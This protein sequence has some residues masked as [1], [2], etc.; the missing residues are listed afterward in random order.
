MNKIKL[1]Q[2]KN[3]SKC[4]YKAYISQFNLK[5]QQNKSSAIRK[6]YTTIIQNTEYNFIEL[7]SEQLKTIISELLEDTYFLTKQEKEVE[8]TIILKHMLRYIEFENRIESN[9][10][11]LSKKISGNVIIGENEIEVKCDMVFENDNNIEIVKYRTSVTKLSL[12]ARTESN[13]IPNDMELFLLKKLGEQLY[14]EQ[15]KPIIS[16]FYHLKGKKDEKDLYKQFLE[17]KYVLIKQV[18]DLNLTFGG[19]KKAQ[20]AIDKAIKDISDVLYF[21][22]S[23][24]N[25]V[26]TFDYDNDLSE[27]IIELSNT[28]LS[29]KSEKCVSSDC[30][31]CNFSTL[32][33]HKVVEKSVLEEVKEVIK[34]SKPMKPTKAQQEVIDVEF[35]NYRVNASAG[36]GKTSAVVER[37]IELF[38][39][40][41]TT[42][43]ILLITYTSKGAEQLK[44]KISQSNMENINPKDLNIFTF[45]GFGDSIISKEWKQLGF[46]EQPKLAST[47]DVNDTIKEL[48]EEYNKIEWLNYKNPL[49]N[50]PYIKG[51]FIQLKNYFNIIK[52][53][54]YN[55]FSLMENI[56]VK[57]KG[58]FT[59]EGLED[60]SKLIFEMYNKFN[61]K[62]FKQN[63]LQYQDQLLYLIKLLEN[64]ETML[65][66][67]G[68]SHIL[69]DEFQDSNPTQ[70]KL[71]HILLKYKENKSFMVVGDEKQSIFKFNCTSP[72]NILNFHKE[73]ENVKDINLAENF[74]STPQICNVANKL[75]RLNSQT[76]NNDMVSRKA[77]GELPKL[78]KFKTLSDENKYIAD[79]IET[80]I[81]EGISKHEICYIA[82]TKKEL[83]EMQKCLN[84]RNIDN[85]V[86][87]SELYLDN[88]YVQS[89]INLSNFFKDMEQ[90]YYLMEYILVTVDNFLTTNENDIKDV[91][92]DSKNAILI[93]FNKFEQEVNAEELKIKYF[94]EMVSCI[95]DLDDVA[96][97]FMDNINSKTFSTF[98]KLLNYLHKIEL[99]KDDTSIQKDTDSKKMDAVIL[100]TSHS[101]KGKEWKVVINS[102]NKFKYEGQELEDLEEERRLLFVSITRAMDLLYITVN[103]NNDKARS[104]GKYCGFADQLADVEIIDV[105]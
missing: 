71:L 58:E 44:S 31:F 81:N 32:C 25:N 45:N 66:C 74:R 76:L 22:N 9:R 17:D 56:L 19:D 86:E 96:K 3:I 24:G 30:D 102:I 15:D 65:S 53:F 95:T 105:E 70:V 29:F 37:V 39:K 90:D 99:Y 88:T 78:L 85:V 69:V 47:I 101:S 51:A 54:N 21:D 49:I 42:Q 59:I 60:K 77:D 10:K 61:E 67:Y 46:T 35:G 4:P 55:E 73:F 18:Q 16:S 23:T 80:K 84:D 12:K 48:L 98:N 72:E 7:T 33:N 94:N 11:I 63:L 93:E 97:S 8:E 91:V 89:I 87:A 50:F 103:I 34:E 52:S 83:L 5:T 26:I 75:S 2:I 57:E 28:E 36:A 82:R 43:Q 62:L 38:K 20:K 104:K 64:D 13:K 14:S 92:E 100:T 27:K 79:L 40:G 68:Y 1:Y 6:V 41:Y